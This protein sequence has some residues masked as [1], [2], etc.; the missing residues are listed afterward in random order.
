MVSVPRPES[1]PVM[2]VGASA[3]SLP[4]RPLRRS[5]KSLPRSESARTF[6]RRD[7]GRGFLKRTGNSSP[8]LA[9]FAL[10]AKS[11]ALLGDYCLESSGSPGLLA[12]DTVGV[13][14]CDHGAT[15]VKLLGEVKANLFEE[16]PHASQELDRVRGELQRARAELAMTLVQ[17]ER[18]KP[19]CFAFEE[20]GDAAAADRAPAEARP[21][22]ADLEERLAQLLPNTEALIEYLRSSRCQRVLREQTLV[23][24]T[25]PGTKLGE[26]TK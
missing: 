9:R 12:S 10:E 1:A 19:V 3:A 6:L 20:G 18:L 8:P 2:P 13:T 5:T 24:T 11:L 4:W 21:R 7:H 15:D 23:P 17:H 22:V 25:Q 26:A 14:T 16:K